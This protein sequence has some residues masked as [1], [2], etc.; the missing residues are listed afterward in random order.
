MKKM[1]WAILLSG[2]ATASTASASLSQ[3]CA[4]Y[5]AEMD[6][7]FSELPSDQAAMLKKQYEA[8]KEN[9]SSLPERDQEQTCSHA[10]DKLNSYK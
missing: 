8:N 9:L 5:F 6:V 3:T 10:L 2:F 7:Y 4:R 1:L